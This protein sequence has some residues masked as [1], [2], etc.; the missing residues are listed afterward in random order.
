MTLTIEE[1]ITQL[2]RA[3]EMLG[4]HLPEAG[5]EARRA[6]ERIRG[7]IQVGA[8]KTVVALA[9]ATGSGK[10]SLLNRLAGV[11][12]ARVAPV[13]PTTTHALAVSGASAPRLLDWMGIEARVVE[14]QV[15][16]NED[17]IL[18]DLPDLDSVECE[19]RR[20]ADSVIERADVVI[21]VLDPQK[22]ADAVIHKDYLQSFV[23]H[24]A[25]SIVA[26]N[27]IDRVAES[28]R[29]GVLADVA[30]LVARDGLDATVVA[31]SAATG[32]G[33]ESLRQML[34]ELAQERQAVRLGLAAD[35]RS[36][37]AR[38]AYA[39]RSD[40]GRAVR[41]G[42]RADFE[43]V[44]RAVAQAAGAEDVARAA[45]QSYLL[46]AGK[47]T[48]WPPARFVK[49]GID[50]LVRLGLVSAGGRDRPPERA[51]NMVAGSSAAARSAVS[52]YAT[53]SLSALPESWRKGVAVDVDA[54]ASE[55]VES[56]DALAAG[57][58]LEHRRRP[59]WWGVVGLGHFLFF[60]CA[61]AGLGWLA[62]LA[63]SG[64]L[65]IR[66]PEPP[67]VGPVSM[68]ALLAIGG[69]AAGWALSALAKRWRVRS[70]ARAR[71][72]VR[73]RLVDAVGSRAEQTIESPLERERSRYADF[74]EC[75]A[76]LATVR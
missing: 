28:E 30:E 18:V 63:A 72:R 2:D 7:R 49:R 8:D 6:A 36:E 14:P 65:R 57:V 74:M 32:E 38:L 56:A 71:S 66:I 31:T 24:G 46:R 35:L 59:G 12:C 9:G 75:V 17:M 70:A 23:E 67:Y 58:D 60:A 51:S 5:E 26:L 22:Y 19:H 52:D 16:L 69:L 25:V 37:G 45:E 50:P 21:F 1:G 10:S 54:A 44:A 64:W 68:P 3:L 33:V 73:Q 47:A 34:L 40:G 55:L 29:E 13:R 15:L 20:I 41:N 4:P 39:V 53:A 11:D 48:A 27:Q 76:R 43:P 62:A 61:V 42:D